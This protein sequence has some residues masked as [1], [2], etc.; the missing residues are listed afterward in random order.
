MS[1]NLSRQNQFNLHSPLLGNSPGRN[2]PTQEN[3][4]G[5]RTYYNPN[6]DNKSESVDSAL[7]SIFSNNKEKLKI[8]GE[9][10]LI[11]QKFIDF[12]EV[13]I[14]VAGVFILATGG[15]LSLL[16][17]INIGRTIYIGSMDFG[18]SIITFTAAFI[19]TI[20]ANVVCLGFIHLI[21]TT[22]YLYLSLESQKLNV[23]KL[24]FLLSRN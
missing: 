11:N 24:L 13:C 12:L 10:D 5:K 17:L 23:E 8:T 3:K 4:K 21:K 18:N 20:V 16:E 1:T 22:K 7:D 2:N 9:K 19:G 6:E 14:K 15:I